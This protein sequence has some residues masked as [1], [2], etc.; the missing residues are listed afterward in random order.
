[1]LRLRILGGAPLV[2]WLGVWLALG[3]LLPAGALGAEDVT[4]L[5]YDGPAYGTQGAARAQVA[6]QFYATHGDAYDF[7]VVLPTFE[8]ELGQ[9]VAGYHHPIRNSVQGIGIPQYDVGT[10]YGSAA[11]LKGYM[12]VFQDRSRREK[13]GYFR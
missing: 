11:R 1:M 7:L 2:G 12:D 4:V 3:M 9:D 10:Q 6:Q 5:H 13:C 8:V